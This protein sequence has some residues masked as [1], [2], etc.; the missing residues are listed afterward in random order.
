MLDSATAMLLLGAAESVVGIT[1]AFKPYPGSSWAL[2]A[3]CR[4]H[5]ARRP[6]VRPCRAVAI[7]ALKDT[8]AFSSE[9]AFRFA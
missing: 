5:G 7:G 2:P 8:I 1:D 4:A 9:V 6:A 3:E